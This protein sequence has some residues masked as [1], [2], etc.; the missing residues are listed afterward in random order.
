MEGE[1]ASYPKL[2]QFSEIK[3]NE[4]PRFPLE[5]RTFLFWWGP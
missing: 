2:E 1:Q 3:S 4:R 5:K